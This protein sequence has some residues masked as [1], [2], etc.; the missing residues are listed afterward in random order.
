MSEFTTTMQQRVN[1]LTR[2]ETNLRNNILQNKDTVNRLETKTNQYGSETWQQDFDE[3]NRWEEVVRNQ[4]DELRSVQSE[5]SSLSSQ[6]QS[7]ELALV[8][9][10][11]V[12][13]DNS[14]EVAQ[15]QADEAKAKRDH[16]AREAQEQREHEMKLAK[17]ELMKLEEQRKAAEA[18]RDAAAL[19]K[20]QE[21]EQFATILKSLKD[22]AG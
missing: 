2:I 14:L 12:H 20:A 19:A 5:I 6:I 3:R 1:E 13:Y 8:P 7:H 9:Q 21:S 16:E 4:E 10:P 18:A 15:I 11:V 22:D 17:I